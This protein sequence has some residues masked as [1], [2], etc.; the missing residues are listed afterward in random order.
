MMSGLSLLAFDGDEPLYNVSPYEFHRFPCGLHYE[1]LD[2][3]SS[4]MIDT[5]ASGLW[6]YRKA[7]PFKHQAQVISLGECI[8]PL[9]SRELNGVRLSLKVD[10][11]FPSGSY[12]DRGAAVMLN[13]L[14]Q[15]LPGIAIIEDSS[16]N[17]GA[18]IA[19]YAAAAEIPC[20]IIASER[21]SSAKLRQIEAVGA[22]LIKISGSREEVAKYAMNLAENMVY[23][24]H[25]Y[26]PA[27]IAGMQSFIFE[28]WEQMN[29][30]L[31]EKLYLPVGNGTLLLGCWY[32]LKALNTATGIKIPE[33]IAVQ[34]EGCQG[35]SDN[36]V[37][38]SETRAEGIAC[39]NPFRRDEILH[40]VHSSGGEVI[41]VSD[42][43]IEKAVGLL[44]E[45]GWNLEFTGGV[46]LA[47]WLKSGQPENCVL[48]LTGS[49]LKSS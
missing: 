21:A 48:P 15:T 49:G 41:F 19:A 14:Y 34:A 22:G 30:R 25:V 5:D 9:I 28:I 43:E 29:F 42:N 47:G 40:A 33:L 20:T 10:Y 12:K 13:Y 46:A 31:P 18:A 11:L 2:G 24:S 17:A 4:E 1:L 3:F 37:V 39:A 7:Y 45:N 36:P 38:N 35:L 32:G 44:S 16:G 27:F 8:T 23:A 6:R 26:N